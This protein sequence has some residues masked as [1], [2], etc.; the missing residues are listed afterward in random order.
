MFKMNTPIQVMKTIS[1]IKIVR[2]TFEG[3]RNAIST[4]YEK[5]LDDGTVYDRG[6]ERYTGDDF[7]ALI[8]AADTVAAAQDTLSVYNAIKE[9]LYT[10]LAADLGLTGTIV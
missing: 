4:E 9:S 10:K 3:G 8:A 5:L 7:V 1:D 6:R 2:F